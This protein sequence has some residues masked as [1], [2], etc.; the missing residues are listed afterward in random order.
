MLYWSEY[1]NAK[2]Y[3][4]GLNGKNI[5]EFYSDSKSYVNDVNMFGDYLYYSGFTSV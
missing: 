5:E 3:R 2:I 1:Q 4:S